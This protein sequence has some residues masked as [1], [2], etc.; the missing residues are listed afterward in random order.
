MEKVYSRI[1]ST[2]SSNLNLFSLKMIKRIVTGFVVAFITATAIT[3]SAQV[4][5][6]PASGDGSAGN[7]YQIATLDN[8]YWLSQNSAQWGKN[9]LQTAD[10]DATATSGWAGG[11]G[12]SPIGTNSPSFTG[13]YNGL[14]HIITNLTINRPSSGYIGLFGFVDGINAK[15]EKLGVVNAT[16]KGSCC[17]GI[18]VGDNN[19]G[20]IVNCYTTGSVLAV[21]ETGGLVGDNMSNST[22]SYCYSTANVTGSNVDV[23]G[24]VGFQFGTVNNCYA[25]GNVSSTQWT[26]GLVGYFSGNISN[27]YSTGDVT[28]T[29]G[30]EVSFGGFGGNNAG[31]T[32][33]NCYSTGKVI[34]A[35]GINPTDKGFVGLGGGTMTGNFWD[36]ESSGQIT[37]SAGGATGKTTAEMKTQGTFTGWDFAAIWNIEP[38]T[39]SGYPFLR[40]QIMPAEPIINSF[41]PTSGSVGTLVTISGTALENPVVF[42]IGG[43]AAIVISNDGS[44]LVGMVMP[45][46]ATGNISI[47]T[48]GGSV[49]ST[50]IFSFAPSS[51]IPTAQQGNKLVG[52]GNNGNSN[53]GTSIALS[54]DGNTAIV[55]AS[56]DNGGIGAAW[57]YVRTG[58]TW[59]Q[60][61]SKLVGSGNSGAS[62][63]GKSVAISADGNTAVIGGWLDN[64]FFGATWIFTRSG[65]TWT[66]QGS[67]LVGSGSAGTMPMQGESVSLSADGNTVIIGG[68]GDDSGTGAA[69][70]FIRSG[71]TWTQQGTKLVGTGFSGTSGQG[72][73]VSLSSDGN[74]ALIGG[75]GDNSSAGAAWVFTRSGSTWTQQGTKLLGTGNT[76][77]SQL[78]Y[79]V[80]LSG[81]GNTVILGGDIDNSNIGAAWI[82]TRSGSTWSQQGSKLTGI[83]Y[84]GSS[85]HFGQSVSITVDG[86][87]AIVGGGSDNSS[88]GASWIFTRSGSSWS[89]A[90]TKLVGSGYTGNSGQ[91]TSVALS[92]DGSTAV[93]G[94]YNDNSGIGAA[95]VF[96]A[97]GP[98]S[99]TSFTHSSGNAGTLV[100]ISG[101]NLGNPTAITIGGVAAIIISDDGS[102]L[103]AMV[104]P[105]T[106]TGNISITTLGGTANS[107]DN[108]TY[109]SSSLLPTAQQ[110]GKLVGTGGL[111][112][113]QQG[114]SVSVSADGNTAIFGGY[115]DNGNTGA[116]W[117]YVRT[118]STWTQQGNKLV[119]SGSVGAAWQGISVSLSADGNTALVGGWGDNGNVGAVWIFTRAAGTWTQQG[120]KLVGTGYT[121]TPYQGSSAKLS[122]D[123]NTVIVGG[124]TDNGNIGAAWIFT[125]SGSTWTQQGSKLVGTGYIGNPYQGWSVSLSA[126]GNTAI[127]GG[128]QDN[129][130]IGAAWVYTR[131]G[132]TWT[133]QG[134]KLVGTGYIGTS[135]QGWSVS[136]NADGNTAIVGGRTDN[137]NIGASWVY[138]RTG[139]TWTQQGNKLTGT[140]NAGNP[141]QGTSVSLTADGNTAIVGGYGDNNIIGASW[142]YTRT[143]STWTQ[144][145]S[146]LV[147]ADYAGS[148]PIYQGISVSLSA[149]GS[150]ALAGGY[151]DNSGIGAAWVFTPPLPPTISSFTPASGNAGTLVT[152]SGTNLTN[153]FALTIGGKTAIVISNTGTSLVAMVMPG[154]T[155][156]NISI[157]TGGG[158][159]NSAGNFTV[160]PSSV[161]PVAQQGSKLVGTGG[162]GSSQLQGYSVSLS[163][164]GNTAIVGG[165]ADNS[166]IGA[167]WIYIRTG[168]TW[169]QQGSKLVGTGNSGSS[170]QGVS[171][172]LSADGNTAIS[173]GYLDNGGIGAAWI[174]TRSGTTWT[175]QGSKL[176]GA[177]YVGTAIQGRSVSLSADGN[178]AIVSGQN[179]DSNIG[180][181]W[182]FTRSGSAWTQ[183]GSKLVGTGNVGQS[184]LGHSVS[185]SADGNTALVGG[186]GDNSAIG[187]SWI[188]TRT[189]STWT[190]Q[191]SKL[192]GTGNVGASQQGNSVSLSAD[193]NTAMVGTYYDNSNIGAAWIF[194]RSGSTWTQ[195]GSKLVGT[196]YTTLTPYQGYSVSL[197]ADGNTAMVGGSYDNSG[198]GASWFY[199]RSGSN[200]TQQG[201][202][203]VG[204]GYTGTPN[205]GVSVSL[206]ADGNTAMVG[207]LYDNGSIG[208][209]WVFTP[210]LP[211][212]LSSFT[213]SSG[214]AGTLVTI[215]GTN[216]NNPFALTIGGKPAIVI[217]NT[218][219]SLVAMV[220][221]GATTGNISITTGG[222]SVISA[223]NLTVVPSTVLPVA[224]QGSKLVGTSYI[225]STI[226]QGRS[227]SVSADGNTA[228]VGGHG[229]NS[230]IGAAWIYTRTGNAWTQQGKLVGTGNSGA[231]YQGSSVSLSADGNTALVGGPFDNSG[232]G[233]TWIYTRSGSTWTQQGSKLVGS[234]NTGSSQQ[235]ITVS[236]SADGNTALVGGW[237]DN[238]FIGAAWIFTRSGSTWTQQG[239]KLVGTGYIGTP[240]QG[241]SVTLSADGNTAMVGGNQDNSLIG[242]AWIF[243]RTGSV[244]SQQ[245][246]KLVGTG[247]I[248]QSYQGRSV[249]LS[250]D[251]NTALVGGYQ[252]NGNIG[253]AWIYTRTG[254]TWT[255]QGS[256]LVGTGNSGSSYQG[257]SVSLSADGNTALVGGYND[258]GSI[259]ATWIFT[260][261][262][263]NWT[264]QGSK[265]IGTGNIGSSYQGIS[266]SISAD[267]NTAMVSGNGDNSYIGAAWVFTPPLPPT[268]SSF[269]PASGSI[270][271]LVTITGTNLTN[272]FSLTI[273]GK[274]AIVISNTGTS[275]VAMVMP[276][277]TDGKISITTG[278]G[279]VNSAGDFTVIP[280]VLPVA[281]QG[282]KLVGIGN[283]GTSNQGYSVAVSADGNTALVGG[284][285]DNSQTGAAWIYVRSGST[286][287]QQGSK[288]VGTG[289]TGTAMQGISVS[290]SADGNTALV[291]GYKDNGNIGAVWIFTRSGSIWTQQGNK[292]VGT[293]NTT[294]SYQG[295]SVSLSADGNTALVGGEGD[296]SS[297]GAVWIFTR[298]GSTWTQQGSK[299]VGTGNVGNASQ[300]WSVSLSADG[301][302][303]LVG[304]RNDNSNIGAAWIYTRTGSTW[305]QQ[306]SKLVG[307]GY[308]GSNISQGASVSLSADG[309]TAIIGGSY[310]NSQVG[311]AWIY[312]RS[313]STW[314]QQG[315][316]LV[317]TGSIGTSWQGQSVSLSADGNEA[318]IGGQGD[319]GITGAAW[320]FTRTGSDWTQQGTKLIGTGN[321]AGS[322]E[323]FSV[324]LSADG[325]SAL[326]GGQGDNSGIGAAWVFTQAPPP[327]TISSFT[328]VSGNAGTMV[329]I[330]GTNLINPSALTIGGKAAIVISND[331]TSLVAMVMPGATTGII[332]LTADGGSVNSAANFTVVPSTVLPVAQQG[333]KLLGTGNTVNSQQ[334]SSVSVSADGNTAIVGGQCDNSNIGAAWIYTRTGNTWT[335]QGNKLVG[336]GY[337]GTPYQGNSV[338]L[339]ADGN[340]AIVGGGGDNG[341]IGAAWIFTRSG[342]TW[343]QQG[344]KLVGTGYSGSSIFQG[345]SVSLSA[346]GNTAIV[347]G[348]FD[349]SQTGAAWIYVRSGSTWAQQ[350]SKL[351]GTGYT[352]TAM[353]GISVSL[354]A[355]G[356]TALVGGYYDN[357]GI[358]AVW[359]YTRTGGT[360]TQQGG[361][362]VGTGNIGQ[363]Y[364][365]VRVSLS[366]DGNTALAGGRADNG[367]T[368]AV[369]IFTR[370]GTTWTQQG[371]KLV[372]TGNIGNALQGGSVSISAD[373][374]TALVGGYSDNTDIGAVWIYTRSGSVWTQQGSKLVGTGYAGT[375]NQGFSVSLSADGKTS[376]VGGYKDNSDIGA[377]WIFTPPISPIISSFTP[378][379]GSIGTLVTISGTDLTNP[380][381]LTI[382]GKPA[383]VISNTGTSLVAMVMPEATTG[384]ISIT[385]G[386]GTVNSA[387]NFTVVPS[388]VHPTAQQGSKLVG[389]GY[390]GTPY[391]GQSVSL[392]ADGNTAIVGGCYDNSQIGAAWIYTRTGSTWTQQGS[393]LVGTGYIGTWI[394]QGWS[395]SLS[396][397]GNTALVGGFGDNGNIGAA[398][399]FT[400]SGSTWTQQGSKLVGTGYTTGTPVQGYSVSLSADGSTA[401][402]GGPGDDSNVGAAWIYTRSGSTWMQQGSKLVGTGS[403]GNA[404]QGQSVSLSADGNTAI[405]GGHGDDSNVGAA[406]IYVHT[407]STWTQQGAKLVGSGG[408]GTQYQ[409]ISVSLNADGNTAIVGGWR[410]NSYVGAAWIYTRTSST[411][412]QQGSK[413][414]GSGYVGNPY[415]GFSVSLSADGNIAIVGGYKDSNIG[416]AWIYTRSGSTWTQHGNKVVGTG[417]SGTPLQGCSVSL[418]A[419]G[420]TALV[421]G[422]DDNGSVGAAWV[423]TPPLPPTISSFT[424]ASGSIGTLVT[425]SGTDLTNPFA[426]AIGG[427]P[428]IVISNDGS[429]LV[430]MVMPGATTGSISITTGG[431]SINS[432][433]NFTVIPSVLPVAQQGSKLVGTGNTGSPS[434]GWSVSVSADGNTA[435]VGGFSDNSYVGAAW[436]YVR[437][438]ST[439]SQQGS[440]LVGTGYTGSSYQGYSVSLSADGNTALVGGY[441]DNGSIGAAWVYTRS[442]STWTQQ[443]TKLVGTGNTGSSQ[444]GF[445]VSL[446]ADGNTAIVCGYND[447]SGIGAAWIYNRIGN[448]WTQQGSKLIGTGYTGT[449][450]QGSSVSLSADGNTAIVGGYLDNSS[451]GAAWIYTR[452]GTT[453]TQQG[454]KLV[455]S[456]NIGNAQQGY[457]VSLSA[458]GNTAI[459]G[460]YLDNSSIGA[461]WIYTRTGTTWT[462]QGSKL[463]GSGYSGT[464]G[465][466]YSVSLSADGNTA[467]VGGQGDN[468]NIGAAWIYTRNGSTWTQQGSKI[469]GTGYAGASYQGRSVS[470]SADGNTAIV[471]GCYDNGNIGAVWVFTT[472]PPP[473]TVTSFTPASGSIGTLVTISGTDLSNPTAF[474]IGGISA[475]VISNDGSTMVGM[476][477]PGANTDNISISTAGG[478]GNSTGNF[479][480]ISSLLPSAQQGSK[481]V[482]TGGTGTSPQQGSSVSISADG[483]TALVGGNYDNNGV[484]A[485]WIYT[486]TGSTWTQQGSKLIGTDYVGHSG[487]GT[488]V[489]LSSDGNTALV[490]GYYDNYGIGAAWIFTRTGSTWTQQGSKLVGTGNTGNSEQGS[491]VSLSADGNTA[492]VCGS[493]DNGSIGAAWIYNRFGSIWTQQGSKLVG[494]GNTGTSNQGWSASLSADGNTALV[495]G[496]LDN[497]GIGAVWVYVRTGYTWTQQ[498]SKLVGSGGVGTQYQG[499]SVFLSADG[500]T[501]IVGG[502]YDNN[503]GA[504]WVYFRTGSTWTQQG[505][506]LVGTGYVGNPYQ[507]SSVSLSAD[508]NT[509]I[510]GGRGDNGYVGAVWIYTRIG[511]TW[512]QQG[513]KLAGTGNTG[514]SYQGWS[515]SLSA[516]GNTALVGGY[517]DNGN[518]GAAWV[519]TPL[520]APLATAATGILTDGFTAN[521]DASIGAIGYYL[522]VAS[523]AGFTTLL[524]NSGS[525]NEDV[526]AVLTK[527]ITGLTAGTP[528]YY[529]VRAYN[530]NSTS[531]NSNVIPLTTLQ[532]QTIIFGT[533]SSKTYGDAPFIVSATGGGSGNPVTFTSQDPTIASCSGTNGETITILKAGTVKIYA[534]QAGNANYAAAP[535]VEQTLTINK[536]TPV[537]TWSDPADITSGTALSSTQLNA[538]ADVPGTFTYTPAAGVVLS[539]GPNQPLSV[540]FTPDDAVNYSN[541]NKSVMINVMTLTDVEDLPQKVVSVYPNPTNGILTISGLSSITNGKTVTMLISDNTGK[542]MMIKTLESN[543]KSVTIDIS[544]Y[545]NG[546][547]SLVLQTDKERILKRF[548]KQ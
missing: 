481:L 28:R 10:I 473:P 209:A 43:V 174:F 114:N 374:N 255:Q 61:G 16:V 35:G 17:V 201:S 368:G 141:L 87:T 135:G 418:S 107:V 321:T 314:T 243:T 487:Q 394:Y 524:N 175:Q 345:S 224:Q 197:S 14:N 273:G 245:G 447:N 204:T 127:V 67:K 441:G 455:G 421:G 332:S 288:L 325:N 109:S 412:T 362:L 498:G 250:A 68:E 205:Q 166:N 541:A 286:W 156:G 21:C 232:V 296:N 23:G 506:K 153:P 417:Y 536:A 157:T 191:G 514:S 537:I 523:D 301:N 40:A 517:G 407:G 340:T 184:Y 526:G 503:I 488:S 489:S 148:P 32:V 155:T 64:S 391:Q 363:S 373:G 246:G 36:T 33:T 413:L 113:S 457:S 284:S 471:G 216:L 129:S 52:T 461:A 440:K 439:W 203:L 162:V 70:I 302:T 364:Q 88:V 213:P 53:Q 283:T 171:V 183:Q 27:S 239:N 300:G 330:S 57:I 341:N 130:S 212:T 326:I 231:S 115:G 120:G 322:M 4:S 269:T 318:L 133:Q 414:V 252:D 105:G 328:P 111:G 58:N 504:A 274:P 254:S 497:T 445:S 428:A 234:N 206:S 387:G 167:A 26:G 499:M 475:I 15:I 230:Y 22:I 310:D 386:G 397:D 483:N 180:A 315:S 142:L 89:Q 462:Q 294:F 304:G 339:S 29:S 60:Q 235:G 353:Q 138:T 544:Q 280:S 535:E 395:V 139:N 208:A 384:N 371:S 66:Q 347:G 143:G 478:S 241:Y 266:V 248:G 258:N 495:G 349:N 71:I 110:G 435:I 456:D 240:G 215:S 202:K 480:V 236:L 452:T 451:I 522:D 350:G 72:Y 262:G 508:G 392:S 291:G 94:G 512:T 468:T 323:G 81:D 299:L 106:A 154:A 548:V 222:G 13:T 101:T 496:H 467:I 342:T 217:S 223:G 513:S 518:I 3:V 146:K 511:S 380:F 80:A 409:G 477:M 145:G 177:G 485:A 525:G 410:D 453:W 260:R 426:I 396:A 102:S 327:P 443:G 534:N 132:S 436:I 220:M 399:I 79:S 49:N 83:G 463:V 470:L 486:R 228:I 126:D 20:I 165:Y 420:N 311:A 77:A 403:A 533:L 529:R 540:L 336:T 276:E 47:I 424:P 367:N 144:Q 104:M 289:Y 103:V 18:L 271:T 427:K 188:F 458:D 158:S 150:T 469:V 242:A 30:G 308:L 136:L 482:G 39:N 200:W 34:Y 123:G 357:T 438:G 388:T 186:P 112:S 329:T 465:Q 316:K 416:A 542:T 317:G 257:Q 298:S 335:Q 358:G 521:W 24:L 256:K 199:T 343:T 265:L 194:T 531:G 1:V 207:G 281:Q 449:P 331:G 282:R 460:G 247:N 430:G 63:Q 147:G 181:I 344:S 189:G 370:S 85:I 46:T 160:V 290:L 466:G 479:A 464:P 238:S 151:G 51:L 348:S 45:G 253:A 393:K 454:S 515:A 210:P 152:I 448:T 546:V 73:S 75:Y 76:G 472:P 42:T 11:T 293:G 360:W 287:A 84:T 178:T 307:T 279:S 176:V 211:P 292:L 402:V 382:G 491:S 509:A 182:I 25:T 277:A 134:N 74:T 173:G 193:G 69:W 98:P 539:V 312:T 334:G 7:P 93:T 442:S 170:N 359:I 285:F 149:D 400:R 263:S 324:S 422:Y 377:A 163:A 59:T 86:N 516:D 474:T 168:S 401:L 259:G 389:T 96:T 446:S 65:T 9:Y 372:G 12:F 320:I 476:V 365:G 187:A 543:M 50:D 97:Q 494:T 390:S 225:G 272:P 505:N 192:V 233:A 333:N 6:P 385:T 433:S 169:T 309:N 492:L 100:T 261:N 297:M 423:F 108:F 159:V 268:I 432:A 366:A 54:A 383:I 95:W 434:Q 437:T 55:G 295:S 125:R 229:D 429:T 214:N 226:Y 303:A 351:V 219:T 376:I 375:S 484:G 227:V 198:I 195:Q 305:T 547:Y 221:P 122:A 369:W 354:S 190:Q 406:W 44:T 128:N 124:R 545:A 500:N 41:S 355:D 185:L 356:N 56:G 92:S 538:I 19:R 179:D 306:G 507:G 278:G 218:G 118:G 444:Q 405:V 91:G 5:T 419:D 530:A 244:W 249:S 450:H 361:K 337:S 237:E 38:S 510:I 408:V 161:L 502:N 99:I 313:S 267:G 425:I 490:G 48:G 411:W 140:G 415:Q 121:G 62:N 270:G 493:G 459:V 346:D 381:A 404:S 352:G 501:A 90:G 8:L 78:G 398:W 31:A 527:T 131:S 251:G 264:Q 338:S 431:G 196:G 137:S 275:L 2:A 116:A 319:N 378:A 519:F 520:P 532:T 172:S 119:G 37:N 379:S 117:I 528:Y 82:F 164:D